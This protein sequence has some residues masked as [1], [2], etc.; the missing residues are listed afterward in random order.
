MSQEVEVGSRWLEKARSATSSG[1]LRPA[2]RHVRVLNVFMGNT[3]RRVSFCTASSNG[4]RPRVCG[5][6]WFLEHFEP[7]LAGT[8]TE[9]E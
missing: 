3:M 6:D 9:G 7:E 8:L 5:Y 2:P 4:Q 1:K